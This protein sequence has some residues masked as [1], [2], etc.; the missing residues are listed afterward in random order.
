MCNIASFFKRTIK[1]IIPKAIYEKLKHSR[2]LHE[3]KQYYKWQ[4]TLFSRFSAIPGGNE[5]IKQLTC[6]LQYHSHEIEKGLSHNN[7]RAGFGQRAITELT[8]SMRLW[9][10]HNYPMDAFA[11]REALGVLK[12][13]EDKHA[14]IGSTLP[15]FYHSLIAGFEQAICNAD[16]DHCGA[17]LFTYKPND[18]HRT[19]KAVL[20]DRCSLRDYSEEPVD[21]D[22]LIEAGQ[23]A[24]RAPSVCNRQSVRLYVSTNPD[25]IHS[26]MSIQAGMHGYKEPPAVMIITSTL[27]SFIDPTERNEPWVDGGL[28]SMALLGALE[29]QGLAACPLNAMFERRRENAIRQALPIPPDEVLIMFVA[30]GHK[31]E[32]TLH[33]MST[34]RDWHD[35]ITIL[36]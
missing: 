25:V 14:K 12:A 23:L 19:Y 27:T 36:K 9:M 7:F 26:V 31:P 6:Q 32:K 33:P 2:K 20:E 3:L 4:F 13:Y 22:A 10:Q 30:V 15:L 17:S 11:M 21:L 35:I 28:F 18:P 5:G 16:T 8:H 24:M 29:A 1:R 34:R